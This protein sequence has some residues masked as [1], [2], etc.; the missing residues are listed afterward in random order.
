M[1]KLNDFFVNIGPE[2][3]KR[4][5]HVNSNISITDTM[6]CSLCQ[7]ILHVFI[8]SCTASEIKTIYEHYKK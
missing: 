8:S 1:P 3:A 2:L 7:I 5:T 6:P 4:I